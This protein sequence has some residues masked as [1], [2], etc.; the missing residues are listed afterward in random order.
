MRPRIVMVDEWVPVAFERSSDG[1]EVAWF[2]APPVTLGPVCPPEA[3]AAALGL[4]PRDSDDRSPV[5]QV[6]AGTSALIVPVRGLDALRRPSLVMLRARVID[7]A[8]EVSVGGSVVPTIEGE[9][10]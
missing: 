9:L 7:G 4:S 8:R 6:S 3:I 2:L 10:V 5:R 1:A